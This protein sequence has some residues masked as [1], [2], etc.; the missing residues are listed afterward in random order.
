VKKIN[1][2][3]ASILVLSVFLSIYINLPL[4]EEPKPGIDLDSDKDGMSDWFE[5]NIA[6]LDAQMPN[7]R[8]AIILNV[9]TL[10]SRPEYTEQ[11]RK[12]TANLKTFLIEEEKFKAENVFVFMGKEA[13]YENFRKTID[14]L[15][16]SSNENDLVYIMLQGYRYESEGCFTFHSGKDISE[17]EISEEFV[18]SIKFLYKD[19]ISSEEIREDQKI[20]KAAHGKTVT[21]SEFNALIEKIKCKKMLLT[22]NCHG[23]REIIDKIS[24][25]NTVVIGRIR[26]EDIGRKLILGTVSMDALFGRESIMREYAFWSNTLADKDGN[27]YPSIEDLFIGYLEDRQIKK[28]KKQLKKEP[29]KIEMIPKMLDPQGIADNFYFGEATIDG[30]KETDLYLL[31]H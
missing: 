6:G 22:L 17:F 29:Q 10:H 24:R 28:L 23:A 14:F 8:Y 7:E 30:H 3:L 5:E 4:K 21:P 19:D 2:L 1:V 13:T 15:E 20:K 9:T 11:R 16:K 31:T 12:E 26:I 25:E 27:S 18:E